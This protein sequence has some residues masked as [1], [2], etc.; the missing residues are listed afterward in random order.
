[1][2]THTAGIIC[3]LSVAEAPKPGG[4]GHFVKLCRDADIPIDIINPNTLAS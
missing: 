4:T 2:F 1:M 3:L